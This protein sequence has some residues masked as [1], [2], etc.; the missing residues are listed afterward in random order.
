MLLDWHDPA[1]RRLPW[2]DGT[3]AYGVLVSEIMSQQTQAERAAEK[4]RAFMARFPTVVALAEAPLAEV[5]DAWAG[6][7]YNRRAVNLHRCAVVVTEQ[8]GGSVPDRLEA[9]LDLPGV[10]PYTARAVLAFAHGEPVVPVDTNVARV[11]ARVADEVLD[12]RTAQVWADA[13]PRPGAG[14]G[15]AITAAVMDLGASTCTSRGPRCAECPLEPRCGW[16]GGPGPD[17]AAAGAHRPRPQ[18]RFEGSL[19]QARGR[20]VD[21]LRAGPLSRDQA[22]DVAAEHGE[23]ALAGLIADGLVTRDAGGGYALPGH[24]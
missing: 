16:A 15:P 12:R 2:R 1:H 11:L 7:G 19:R 22:L 6:L 18:G 17:P 10:G 24:P 8:H 13:L 5:I 21:A 4:W 9:L 3:D 14:T 23:D 20:V